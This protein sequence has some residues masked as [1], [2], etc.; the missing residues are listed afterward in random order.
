MHGG[1]RCQP[2]MRLSV[3]CCVLFPNLSFSA[4]DHVDARVSDW[5]RFWSPT[6]CKVPHTHFCASDVLDLMGRHSCTARG[7]SPKK[8]RSTGTQ[9]LTPSHSRKP[10]TTCT[11][12]RAPAGLLAKGRIHSLERS[13]LCTQSSAPSPAKRFPPAKEEGQER[14]RDPMKF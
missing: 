10:K 12:R 8:W 1:C 14:C 4:R 3:W 13:A 2:G 7:R 5:L 11:A 9:Y 6:R